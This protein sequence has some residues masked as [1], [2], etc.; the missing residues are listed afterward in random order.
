MPMRKGW[1]DFVDDLVVEPVERHVDSARRAQ[2]LPAA[3][4]LA[5]SAH[6]RSPSGCRVHVRGRVDAG[7]RHRF[8]GGR[9]WQIA[10]ATFHPDSPLLAATCL[11]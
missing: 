6:R 2:G 10:E 1:P 9:R 3:G 7:Q 4:G 11:G 8:H 5:G